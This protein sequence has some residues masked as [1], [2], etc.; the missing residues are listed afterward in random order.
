MFVGALVI[1]TVIGWAGTARAH[2]ETIRGGGAGGINTVGA[3]ITPGGLSAGLRLELREFERFTDVALLEFAQAGEDVHQHARELSGILTAGYAIDSVWSFNLALQA[4][5]FEDFREGTIAETGMPRVLRDTFSGGLGDLLLLTRVRPWTDGTHHLALL[6]GLK[7]PTGS[8]RETNDDGERQ[9]AHNQ[10]GSGSIDFQLGVAYSLVVDW[11]E[12]D[13]DVIGHVRTEGAMSFQAG[14]LLQVDVALS[15]SVW[16]LVF[17]AELNFLASEQDIERDEVLRNSG[18]AT[19][20]LSPGIVAR[21]TQEHALFATFSYP[22]WQELP[23]FQNNE[24]FRLSVSYVFSVNLGPT[25]P[26]HE[27]PHEHSSEPHDHPHDHIVAPT[28]EH[29]RPTADA[30]VE[31]V[32]PLGTV[33]TTSELDTAA[34]IGSGTRP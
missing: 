21:L 6:G 7:L 32:S 13:A 25:G 11:F 9:G 2:G 5:A 24:A 10:P 16:Q 22:I 19:L 15:A 17:V 33:P 30:P 1:C 18:I 23:G 4:N 12:V 34:E 26:G 20:Y 31:G 29:A 8:T 3:L 14:N 28:H 27:H